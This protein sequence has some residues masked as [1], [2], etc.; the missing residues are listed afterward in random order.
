M[1]ASGSGALEA[2]AIANERVVAMSR[3]LR[4][5]PGVTA[6]LH[7]AECRG[8]QSGGRVECYLDIETDWKESLCWWLEIGWDETWSV[9]AKLYAQEDS[10]QREVQTF[11]NIRTGDVDGLVNALAGAVD[12][13]AAS[14]ATFDPGRPQDRSDRS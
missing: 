2:I 10:G 13:I 6:V 14:V 11:A 1:I 4:A 9:D 3:D 5:A 8:F 7:G 12:A